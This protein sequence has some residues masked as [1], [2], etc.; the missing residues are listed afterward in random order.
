MAVFGGTDPFLEGP[1]E[2]VLDLAMPV[3]HATSVL[4][5]DGWRWRP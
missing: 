3:V 1:A 2:A 4:L 5:A